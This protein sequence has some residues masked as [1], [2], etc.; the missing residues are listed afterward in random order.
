MPAQL[1]LIYYFGVPARFIYKR[2]CLEPH[3][4]VRGRMLYKRWKTLEVILHHVEVE[5]TELANDEHDD[6]R[7]GLPQTN[8]Q[9]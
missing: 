9:R 4:V 2:V 7:L 5:R 6:K 8:L 3:S 1:I